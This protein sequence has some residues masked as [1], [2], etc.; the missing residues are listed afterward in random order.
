MIRLFLPYASRYAVKIN[1]DVTFAIKNGFY[2]YLVE[3][4]ENEQWEL[5]RTALF[6]SSDMT[7]RVESINR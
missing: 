4:L 7:R 1:P 5:H 2:Y 6:S 3:D